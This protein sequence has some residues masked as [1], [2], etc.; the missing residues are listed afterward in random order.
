MQPEIFAI[1]CLSPTRGVASLDPSWSNGHWL[2]ALRTCV[3][4]YPA[5]LFHLGTSEEG[6]K[7]LHSHVFTSGSNG[8]NSILF[9]VDSAFPN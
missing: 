7:A 2:G 1:Q 6:E 5:T 8:L 3:G 4:S 9:R